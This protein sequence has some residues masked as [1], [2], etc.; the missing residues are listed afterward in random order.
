MKEGNRN[1]KLFIEEKKAIILFLW[2]FNFVY[3]SFEIFYYLSKSTIYKEKS[4]ISASLGSLSLFIIVLIFGVYFI[5]K[6]NPFIV[7]YIYIYS[8][9]GID[10]VDTILTYWGKDTPYTSGNIVE[11]LFYL[12]SP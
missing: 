12:Y 10:F 5:K 4:M 11:V 1:P 8:Y 7:K 3:Y 2:L 6:G 9:L